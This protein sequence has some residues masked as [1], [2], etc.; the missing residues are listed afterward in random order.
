[1]QI[2]KRY[3]DDLD[4]IKANVKTAYEYFKPNYDR[5]HTFRKF[6]F[7]SSLSEDEIRVLEKIGKPPLEFN[8]T[9]AYISRLRGEFAKQ[10]PSLSVSSLNPGQVDNVMLNVIEGHTRSILFD[11]NNDAFEYDVYMDLLSGGFSTM[12]VFTEYANEKSFDQELRIGRVFDP[13]L[14]GFDMNARLPHKGDGL[15]A[16]E[17]FPKTIEEFKEEFG[18]GY[19]LD[20]VKFMR[21][22]NGFSWSYRTQNR[23]EQILLICD[24]YEKKRKKAKIVQLANGQVMTTDEYETF[25]QKWRD[26]G[27]FDQPP[28][29]SRSRQSYTT[30]ICRTRLIE[31]QVIDYEETDYKYLPLVFVDGNSVLLRDSADG[32]VQQ[33]TRP[34]LYHA[35]DQQRLINFAGQTLANDLEN[36][37]Q[38]KWVMPLEGL[39]DDDE[40]KQSLLNNQI[41]NI[42]LFKAY[43]EKTDGKQ[44]PP[45]REVQRVPTP[46]EVVNTFMSG[47]QVM[48]SIIG[49]YDASLGINDNQ[50]SGIAITEAATQSNA[51][52]MPYIVGFLQGLNQIAQ[53]LVDLMPKYYVT[54]RTIPFTLPDGKKGYV[55]INQPGGLNMEY[56][57]NALQVRIEAGV[58]F[59]I[60]KSR[61][62]QQ[63]VAL[64]QAMPV[65]G[66]FMNSKGLKVIVKNLEGHAMDELEQLADEFMK[67]MQMQQQKQQ[68]QPNP[69]VMKAQLEQ[70]KLAHEAQQDQVENQIRMAEV[71]NDANANTNDRLNLMLK[72]QQAGINAA[73]QAKKANA[74]TYSKAV[75]LALKADHQNHAQHLETSDQ[76]HR[77]TKE[78]L[79]LANQINSNQSTGE[80]QNG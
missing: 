48:Q 55:P 12:K 20:D 30:T 36:L 64:S 10:E 43:D 67:E 44:L 75:E 76:L 47:Q 60:Q 41:G 68:Q 26:S 37:T 40:Y 70:Q 16:F 17:N 58:N 72:Q 71:V 21:E 31:N 39:P 59:N 15:F 80:T 52:A 77:H 33:M 45:P 13:T 6:I 79:E 50:L 74:E 53:I 51:A 35:R 19:K 4:R 54:P 3:R 38:S 49:S 46:P 34:Y 2:A 57:A 42:I 73:V 22:N 61:T 28:V 25:V 14:C 65:F 9:E 66:Q 11:A 8:M 24:Y 1:M 63:I 27:R 23:N 7:K 29:A 18:T 62:L 69:L 56:D 78:A 5:Y 32:A